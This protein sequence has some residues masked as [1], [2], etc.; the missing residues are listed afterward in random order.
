MAEELITPLNPSPGPL[1]AP[2]PKRPGVG[3]AILIIFLATIPLLGIMYLGYQLLGLP[4][5]P[6]EFFN[7]PIRAGVGPW[8]ALVDTLTSA[9][10]AAGGNISQSAPVVQWVLAIGLFLLLALAVGLAFYAFVARRG[11]IP[12]LIDG[13]AI[14]AIF[15]A[16]MIFATLTSSGST[17]PAW[18]Q[19]IWLVALACVWGVVLS[20]A[21]GR[22]FTQDQETVDGVS[23]GGIGRRQFLL[24]FGAGAAAI[25]AMSAAGAALAPG[26][27][28]AQLQRTL[29]MIS[30]DFKVAQREL[31]GSFRRFAIVRG[32][33]NS[34]DESNV[35]ALGAEYP[36]RNYVSIWLGGRSPIVIYENLGT[37]LAAYSTEDQNA[38]VFWLD[39]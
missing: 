24:Q 30:P 38:G 36:D 10:A 8:I 18:L 22:L 3:T 35:L 29:P 7:W 14:G 4:F 16:P 13:L 37:A 28:T 21:F 19:I 27:D 6:F 2:A 33:A 5:I 39:S 1:P 20:Y 34:A 9:G 25:T 26:N 23:E 17:L 11:R 15:A 31:F 32:G 12:D